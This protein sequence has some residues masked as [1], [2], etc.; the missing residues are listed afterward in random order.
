M[1]DRGRSCSQP[2]PK[3]KLIH[4][5]A[6][7]PL[8]KLACDFNHIPA[9]SRFGSHNVSEEYKRRWS[10]FSCKFLFWLY[11]GYPWKVGTVAMG[12]SKMFVNS[13]LCLKYGTAVLDFEVSE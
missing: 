11:Y 7:L 13:F 12:I 4:F 5:I 2:N 6:V 3:L 8:A 10:L 1:E 9:S